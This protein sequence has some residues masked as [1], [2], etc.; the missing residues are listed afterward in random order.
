MLNMAQCSI[1]VIKK[2]SAVKFRLLNES[3]LFQQPQTVLFNLPTPLLLIVEVNARWCVEHSEALW[4]CSI[5]LILFYVFWTEVFP[6]NQ[7]DLNI[8]FIHVYTATDI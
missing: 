7:R 8:L 6:P 5:E 3:I 1:Y 4:R 2:G